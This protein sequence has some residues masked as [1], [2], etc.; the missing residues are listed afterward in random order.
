[1]PLRVGFGISRRGTLANWIPPNV[2][3]SILPR[4]GAPRVQLEWNGG[5]HRLALNGSYFV[6]GGPFLYQPPYA[7]IP[8]YVVA[9]NAA[10]REVARHKLEN[11]SFYL[12][13]GWKAFTPLYLAWKK[14]QH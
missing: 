5:W 3:G 14:S 7:N 8:Y 11:P 10:G 1:M 4:L 6:G 13:N 2:E 9:Y 12:V